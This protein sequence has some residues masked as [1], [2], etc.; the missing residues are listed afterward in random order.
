MRAERK[1][2]TLI[3]LLV[4]LLI[5]GILAAITIAKFAGLKEDAY[6]AAMTSDLRN[7][8]IHQAIYHSESPAYFAGDGSAQ[9]FVATAGVTVAN[10]YDPGPPPTWSATATHRNTTRTCT[11]TATSRD[12]WGISCH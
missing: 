9:G 6:I 4:V 11:I 2:F 12:S 3:E 10:T 8:A 7:L 1:G 5:V